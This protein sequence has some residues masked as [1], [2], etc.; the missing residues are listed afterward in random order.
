MIEEL[1]VAFE[2]TLGK[3]KYAIRN[4]FLSLPNTTWNNLQ[5]K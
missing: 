3:Q 5:E 4:L 2:I 1:C